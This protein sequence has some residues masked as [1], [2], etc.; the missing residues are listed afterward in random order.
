MACCASSVIS[1]SIYCTTNTV[2]TVT[3]CKG[4]TGPVVLCELFLFVLLSKF[5]IISCG[6]F[7]ECILSALSISRVTNVLSFVYKLCSQRTSAWNPVSFS[8]FFCIF[9]FSFRLYDCYIRRYFFLSTRVQKLS[10]LIWVFLFVCFCV[11]CVW[12]RFVCLIFKL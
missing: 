8:F 1:S 11:V 7:C 4:K 9:L 3:V 12:L 2:Y 6:V 5:D 10:K